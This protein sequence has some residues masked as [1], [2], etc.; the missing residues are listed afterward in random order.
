VALSL[1]GESDLTLPRNID[2]SN[3]NGEYIYYVA[4]V[5]IILLLSGNNKLVISQVKVTL[6][7][8]GN[9]NTG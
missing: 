8:Q 9:I 7:L 6:Y 1:Y 4:K 5:A 2:V 3:T